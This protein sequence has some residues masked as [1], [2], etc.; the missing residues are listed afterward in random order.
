MNRNCVRLGL[1]ASFFDSP[2][3]MMNPFS[4]STAYDIAKL[5]S[6]CLNDARF[7]EIVSTPKYTCCGK[8]YQWENTH[9][10]L[11]KEGV[12]AIKTGVT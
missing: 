2:H 9:K 4:K 10:M 5:S 12:I 11:G 7:V 3:G 6:Q 8:K 1:R